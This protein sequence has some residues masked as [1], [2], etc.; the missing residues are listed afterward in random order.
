MCK[1]SATSPHSFAKRT[2]KVRIQNGDRALSITRGSRCKA[3]D[4]DPFAVVRASMRDAFEV[5]CDTELVLDNC[6]AG[7]PDSIV[8][9]WMAQRMKKAA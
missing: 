5:C 8:R 7:I 2:F 1:Q 9:N 4:V 3:E 6:V